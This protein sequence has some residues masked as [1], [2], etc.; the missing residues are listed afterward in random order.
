MMNRALKLIVGVL[1]FA[2]A[3]CSSDITQLP[4]TPPSFTSIATNAAHV[5]ITAAPKFASIAT[6]ETHACG[7]TG[8]GEI[9]C[10]GASFLGELGPSDGLQD[11]SARFGPGTFCS[12]VAAPSYDLHASAVVA[13]G[14]FTCALDKA[15]LASCWGSN[16]YG[17]GGSG[18]SAISLPLTQ[19][20]GG[21]QFT[22]LVAGRWHVCGITTTQDAYCWGWDWS[23]Q[24]GAGDVSS[25]QCAGD[26]CSRV[27]RLVVGGHKWAQLAATDRATCG[28]TTANELYCWGL[29]VGGS[30]GLYCQLPDNLVGCTRTPIRIAPS[31]SYKFTSI[32]DV[33]RC[34][35]KLDGT[36]DC[37]GANYW[38]QFGDGTAP[39]YSA[40]PVTAAGGAAYP[41]FVAQRDANCALTSDGRAQC[42]GSN[43]A[44]QIGDGSTQ[45]ALVPTDVSGA[46]RFAA[47]F[48]SG[49]SDF[50]CGVDDKGHAYCWGWGDFGQ[51]GDGG[52]ASS[53]APVQVQGVPRKG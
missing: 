3:G 2:A 32:G 14:Y 30:D 22:Q 39:T 51:L 40:T 10:W 21:Q 16:V 29:D 25:D 47:L 6:G 50:A 31:Q 34:E 35:Q 11:C 9:Y 27:P 48:S 20:S 15:G 18:S 52:F 12:P 33:H 23:G 37:W 1:V 49:N 38:G 43:W 45:N 46:H 8:K 17:Q 26:P 4:T 19:V 28:I 42:W 5:K 53:S 36:L 41:S 7:I 24:L 13:G 44:G